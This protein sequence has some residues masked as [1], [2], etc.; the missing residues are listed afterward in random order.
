LERFQINALIIAYFAGLFAKGIAAYIINHHLCFPQRFYLWQSLVAPLLAGSAH[1][2][3]LRW[4]TGLIWQG[5]QVTS[6]LIFLI[7]ILLSYP[8]FAFFYGLFGGWDN[9]TL[10]ELHHSTRL[11]NFM[12]P[13]AWLFWASTA[14]GARI[15]PLHG[16]FKIDIRPTALEEAHTLTQERV[17][18]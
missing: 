6:V 2:L 8:V 3:V 18:V 12:R 13:L 5:D 4:L 9:D 10:A 7:G 17:N 11:S 1:Y 16:R 14:L 15:S